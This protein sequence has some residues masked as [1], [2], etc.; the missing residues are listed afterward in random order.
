MIN[1]LKH[2]CCLNII[3]KTKSMCN[4]GMSSIGSTMKLELVKVAKC[5]TLRWFGN[6][7]RIG[8]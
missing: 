5:S 8:T 4:V 3:N 2:V 7:I 6:L 1:D